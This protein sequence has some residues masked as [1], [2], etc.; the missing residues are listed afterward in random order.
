M[1][2][3]SAVAVERETVDHERV[4]EQV[5]KL[6]GVADAACSADP[7]GVFDVAVD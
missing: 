6:A 4:A 3:T 7:E 1:R 5:E 2:V